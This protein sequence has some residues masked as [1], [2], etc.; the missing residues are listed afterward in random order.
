MGTVISAPIAN[1][2]QRRLLLWLAFAVAMGWLGYHWWKG[3]REPAWPS[4]QALA[5]M[6]VP[7]GFRVTLSAAEPDVTQPIAIAI[8]ARGRIWV[9]ECHSYPRWN[10]SHNDRILVF[11]PDA[12]GRFGPPTV[13]CDNL[14]NLSGIEIGFGGVWCVCAPHLLFIPDADRDD[15]PDGPPEVVLDGWDTKPSMPHHMPNHLLWGMDGWLYGCLGG[16]SMSRVGV[17]GST[18]EQRLPVG[19][20]IWRFH[21][22]SKRFEVVARG[23]VNPWGI[24]FDARGRLFASNNIVAHLWHIVPGG[25]YEGIEIPAHQYELMSGCADHNHWGGANPFLVDAR[26]LDTAGGGHA[27]AG[28][29]IYQ[30][31][32]WPAPYRGAAFLCNIHGRRIN[33]DTLAERGA[34]V[35]AQHGGDLLLASDPGFRGIDLKYGPDGAVY[36]CDWNSTGE[37]HSTN[38][39]SPS[40]TGR[41]YR[42]AHGTPK[43]KAI[44]LDACSDRVLADLHEEVNDWYSRRARLV[45]AARASQRSL[46]AEAIGFLQGM[47]R[48]PKRDV[49][50]RLRALWT[51]HAVGGFDGGAAAESLKDS[52]PAIRAWA[53][54]FLTEGPLSSDNLKEVLRTQAANERDETVQVELLS[55]L[56]RLTPPFRSEVG[57]IL[58]PKLASTLPRNWQRLAWYGVEPTVAKDPVWA[59]TLNA[60]IHVP[61]L[62]YA[63]SR[64]LAEL[65]L[66][67][68]APSGLDEAIDKLLS[69]LPAADHEIQAGSL[70]GFRDGLSGHRTSVPR[71]WPRIRDE[72]SRSDSTE[73][74]DL[75]YSIGAHFGDRVAQREL[76]RLMNDRSLPTERRR[77]AIADCAARPSEETRDVLLGLMG[78]A[79]PAVGQAAILALAAFSDRLVSERLL[80]RYGTLTPLQ[81]Q[82]AMEVFAGHPI[83]ARELLKH[84]EFGSIASS[85]IPPHLVRQM[86]RMNDVEVSTKL[87]RLWGEVRV[88]DADTKAQIALLKKQLTPDRLAHANP[89]KGR[90]TFRKLC[91]GCH[92]FQDEGQRAGPDLSGTAPDLDTLLTNI[93]DPNAMVAREFQTTVIETS[94]GRVL[95]GLVL[96]EN[97]RTLTLRTANDTLVI[98]KKEIAMRRRLSESFMPT[99]LL[100]NLGETEIADL[101]RYLMVR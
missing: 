35:V 73:I 51:L 54:R 18:A 64:R 63:M 97:E 30:G 50:L 21:P 89:S 48:D 24:D 55:T 26:K 8:D 37:C 90:E 29:M 40:A 79:D 4:D 85:E 31:D 17:V 36:V 56:H 92:V 23:T 80:A 98:D 60:T 71:V 96:N 81:K 38:S 12:D 9:A 3:R 53:L 62:N 94:A 84:V 100:Q 49:E 87:R 76:H 101:F 5:G 43:R 34:E 78:D 93:V 14:T 57:R 39:D 70:R 27:H 6:N 82:A 52:T 74:R 65:T 7:E 16:S 83:H 77:Q 75:V 86:F 32:N 99:G 91:A 95:T 58:I 10:H 25:S 44:D 20:G 72:L 66:A 59:G 41:I 19:P 1:S 22:V 33:Y 42:I 15:R 11:T 13:F 2:W 45:L 47:L 68:G 46:D 61:F 28:L 69:A 88:S 67:D